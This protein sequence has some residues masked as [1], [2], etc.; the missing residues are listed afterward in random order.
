[1]TRTLF[2]SNLVAPEGARF[3]ANGEFPLYV[4]EED[5]GG[6]VGRLSRVEA[7]G[8]HMPFCTGFYSIEDVVQDENGRLYVSEDGSGLVIVI[9]ADSPERKVYL[10]FI[11]RNR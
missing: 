5:I 10:P 7:D 8:S 3:A 9:E 1:M 4:A 2:T 6:G 11:S